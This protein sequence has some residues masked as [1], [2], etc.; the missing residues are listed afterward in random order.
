MKLTKKVYEQAKAALEAELAATRTTLALAQATDGASL[1]D[2]DMW[3]E[4][5]DREADVEMALHSLAR[6]WERRNWTAADYNTASL[7]ANNI[8]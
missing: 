3:D 1:P 2:I 6:N 4:Y 8:D 7:I 5:H